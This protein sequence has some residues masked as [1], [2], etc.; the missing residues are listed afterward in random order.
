MLLQ[1]VWEEVE[2][3]RVIQTLHINST[4]RQT[5]HTGL[6][7]KAH[8]QS[9][10]LSVNYMICVVPKAL[11]LLVRLCNMLLRVLHTILYVPTRADVPPHP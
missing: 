1:Y 5:S 7:Q 10:P 2:N 3:L 11:V 8:T 6:S 9:L 4:E